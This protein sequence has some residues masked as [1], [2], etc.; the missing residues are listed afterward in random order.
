MHKINYLYMRKILF[1]LIVGT[2]LVSCS[3][4]KI[5]ISGSIEGLQN[6]SIV[7]NILDVNT[8]RIIDTINVDKSGK[9]SYTI[10][11]PSPTPEFYYLFYK[12]KRLTSMILSAGDNVIIKSD[13]LGDNTIDGSIESTLLAGIEKDESVVRNKYDSLVRELAKLSTKEDSSRINYDLGGLYVKQKQAAIKEIYSHPYSMTNI[14]LLYQRFPGDI[15]IFGASTDYMMFQRVY[16]SLRIYYPGSIYV[17]RL[18]DEI[19]YRMQ[20]D[21]FNEKLQGVQEMSFPE[22][23][24][25]DI[26][27][28]KQSLAKLAENKVVILSFWTVTDLN[29]KM[30]NLDMIELYEKYHDKGLEIYQ[31]SVDTDKTAWAMAVRD[32]KLPWISVCDGLGSNSSAVSSYNIQKVPTNFILDREGTIVGRDL[33]DK[34]LED[35]MK[36]LIR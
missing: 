13:T 31:V 33:F 23:L 2:V 15:P 35:K 12:D 28:E 14:A 17:A 18:K 19:D 7:L 9:F 6:G 22:L 20:Y 8:Q 1:F 26:K 4:K 34:A 3:S 10:S 32:Q 29:Q 30:I 5:K 21:A 16:D 27:S 11:K 24:L 25:P 36:S